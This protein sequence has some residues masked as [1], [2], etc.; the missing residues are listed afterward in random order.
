VLKNAGLVSDRAEG[1][2]RVYAVNAAGLEALRA[3]LDRFWT[4]ALA[5]FKTVAERS[6]R[7]EREKRTE[8]KSEANGRTNAGDRHRATRSR[9]RSNSFRGLPFRELHWAVLTVSSGNGCERWHATLGARNNDRQP[10]DERR[11]RAD[12][13][14]VRL[15]RP[16]V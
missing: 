7:T 3:D 9:D 12:A 1:T 14:A 2:R 11:T 16:S 4:H 15:D 6:S 10:D 13:G 5:A 8:K